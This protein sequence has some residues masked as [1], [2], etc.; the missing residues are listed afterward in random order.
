[1]DHVKSWVRFPPLSSLCYTLKIKLEPRLE[2][3][4]TNHNKKT[5]GDKDVKLAK[6]D[7]DQ[8][9]QLSG[10]YNVQAVPTGK[11]INFS[12]V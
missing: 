11:S 7:I 12:T 4:I 3:A 6:V 8:L 9:E 2:K 5:T 1:M 10:K